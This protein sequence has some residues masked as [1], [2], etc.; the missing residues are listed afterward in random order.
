MRDG[1]IFYGSFYEAIE[2]LD[3]ADQLEV[4]RAICQYALTGEMPQCKG[5]AR[6]IMKLVQPQI[7]ANN[8]RRENGKKGADVTNEAAPMRQEV[9]TDAATS[10]QDVGN[11]SATERQE[12]GTDAAKEKEKGK[13]KVKDKAKEDT[14]S[15]EVGQIVDH[16]NEVCD[17]HFRAGSDLTR[18]H[19][20]ARL[21]ENYALEDF[22]TVI[23]RKAKQWKG[24]E[25]EKYLRPETLF[26]SKFESYLNEKDS[27]APP[28]RAAP[29]KK[30][31]WFND[32]FENRKYDYDALEVALLK[33]QRG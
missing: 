15:R 17:T 19:I 3:E 29:V 22:F 20:V 4:Y 28:G 5:A 24:T 23:D 21:R 12:V 10:R 8:K 26:G 14:Y 11:Q 31:N 33:A 2:E 27:S 32:N 18:K 16:L 7:D 25:Q 13:D 1:F 6:A 30:K 9:G